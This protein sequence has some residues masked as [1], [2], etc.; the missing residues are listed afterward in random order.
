MRAPTTGSIQLQGL[1]ALTRALAAHA[2]RFADEERMGLHAP[3]GQYPDLD[4]PIPESRIVF[5]HL[6]QKPNAATNPIFLRYSL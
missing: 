1:K 3:L 4:Y 6:S 2:V 5:V